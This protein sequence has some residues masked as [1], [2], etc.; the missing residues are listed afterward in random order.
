MSPEM[1]NFPQRGVVEDDRKIQL[2]HQSPHT[3]KSEQK[4]LTTHHTRLDF[5]FHL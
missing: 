1:L 3:M 2:V 5:R 4:I